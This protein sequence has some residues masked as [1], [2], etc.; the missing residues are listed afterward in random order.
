MSEAEVKVMVS[1]CLGMPPSDYCVVKK[2]A[3]EF[4]NRSFEYVSFNLKHQEDK[5][6]VIDLLNCV[7]DDVC[8]VS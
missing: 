6:T 8:L 1:Q 7:C 2:L 4:A 5:Q 3:S